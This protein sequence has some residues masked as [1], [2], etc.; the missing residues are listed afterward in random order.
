MVRFRVHQRQLVMNQLVMNM[1]GMIGMKD[2]K[3]ARA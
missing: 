3:T 2:K 1:C